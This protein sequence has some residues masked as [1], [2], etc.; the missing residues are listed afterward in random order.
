MLIEPTCENWTDDGMPAGGV[1]FGPGLCISWQNGPLGRGED[2][3]DPNGAFVE[4][5]LA[6]A[7]RRLQWYQ[8]V[9]GGRFACDHNVRAID[10]I[11]NALAWL[12]NR[13][14]EREERQVEGTHAE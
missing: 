6:A 11:G 7:R 14:Y 9:A 3:K 12:D 8:E 4:S 5:V 10:A 1:A 13:T 2:R